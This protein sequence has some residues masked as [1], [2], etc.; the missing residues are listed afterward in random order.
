MAPSV[1]PLSQWS[2]DFKIEPVRVQKDALNYSSIT[3]PLTFVTSLSRI[4]NTDGRRWIELALSSAERERLTAIEESILQQQPESLSFRS[5]VVDGRL[6]VWVDED[7]QYY[8]ADKVLLQEKPELAPESVVR[9]LVELRELAYAQTEFGAL[10]RAEQLW[11]PRPK[12]VFDD[13]GDDAAA[14]SLAL[15][16]PSR[17]GVPETPVPSPVATE[18]EVE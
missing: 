2:G 13:T 5:S 9:V 18:P 15:R 6:E 16:L 3:P 12:F 11:M 4:T 7:T 17:G 10:W 8:S 1:M 14:S